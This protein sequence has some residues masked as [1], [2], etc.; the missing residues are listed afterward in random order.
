MP[1]SHAPSGVERNGETLVPLDAPQLQVAARHPLRVERIAGGFFLLSVL[2]F[3]G[4]G[5]AY[6]QAAPSRWLG[7]SLGVGAAAFGIA[8]DLVG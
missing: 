3:A 2:A 5:A 1:D 6:W 8:L 4:F 7:V